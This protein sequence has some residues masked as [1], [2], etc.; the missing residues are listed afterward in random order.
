MYDVR[1]SYAVYGCDDQKRWR[2]Y[3]TRGHKWCVYVSEI[4]FSR[5]AL[6][7]AVSEHAYPHQCW[8]K[9][10]MKGEYSTQDN[11]Y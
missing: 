4:S 9:M 2:S 8:L 7:F 5:S 6:L 3:N 11:M 10:M 1:E